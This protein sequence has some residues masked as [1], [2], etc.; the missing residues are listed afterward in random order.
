MIKI[1]YLPNDFGD[2]TAW[3]EEYIGDGVI[4]LPY[5]SDGDSTEYCIFWGLAVLFM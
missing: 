3:S 1:C 4:K 2:G 5:E